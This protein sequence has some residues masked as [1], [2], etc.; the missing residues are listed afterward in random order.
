MVGEEEKLV[1]M[2]LKEFK[3]CLII[4]MAHFYVSFKLM[5]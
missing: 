1:I 5:N 2:Q 4:F 3:T